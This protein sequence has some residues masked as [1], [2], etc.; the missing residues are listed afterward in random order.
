MKSIF[1]SILLTAL[2]CVFVGM[3]SV[4]ASQSTPGRWARIVRWG[5]AKYDFVTHYVAFRILTILIGPGLP[6]NR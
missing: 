2:M 1:K 5:E 3:G 6:I 4:S